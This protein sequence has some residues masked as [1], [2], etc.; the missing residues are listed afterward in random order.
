[1]MMMLLDHE[2]MDGVE[3]ASRLADGKELDGK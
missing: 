3:L 1:M 2:G